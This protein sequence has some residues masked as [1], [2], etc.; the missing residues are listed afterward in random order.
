MSN[1]EDFSDLF[2][3]MTPE[4]REEAERQI[5][6]YLEIMMSIAMKHHGDTRPHEGRSLLR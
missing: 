5:E 4:E 1:K 6:G 2:E 3:G